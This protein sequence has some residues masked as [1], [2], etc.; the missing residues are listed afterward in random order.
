MFE[1]DAEQISYQLLDRFLE[2]F[3]C[4]SVTYTYFKDTDTLMYTVYFDRFIV[5]CKY[6]GYLSGL[7]KGVN[8]NTIYGILQKQVS[9]NLYHQFCR[10]Y[11]W[12]KPGKEGN[13]KQR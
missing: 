5:R 6:R 8:T 4:D 1:H 11:Y 9:A 13:G 12:S 10:L 7:H 2:T 3:R